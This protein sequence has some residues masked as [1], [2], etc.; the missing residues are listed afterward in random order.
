MKN[1]LNLISLLALF[2]VFGSVAEAAFFET[3]LGTGA[4]NPKTEVL[5]LQQFLFDRGFLKVAPTGNYLGLTTVAVKAFQNSQGIETTGFFGPLSRAA[6]NKILA[7]ADISEVS[8]FS[9]GPIKG[10]N[11]VASV[12]LSNTREI[13]WET[14][15]YPDNVGVNI[16]LLR[17]ISD[18]PTE[19]VLVRQIAK[20]TPNDGIEIWTPVVSDGDKSSLF[21]EVTCSTTYAFSG[22]CRF[23]GKTLK[24][25]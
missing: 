8:S 2:F 11:L 22:E 24:A 16:N 17:K 4:N 14:K 18:N 23:S 20:D 13:K 25:F 21:I 10:S 9:V 12:A 6:A 1:Y 5:K 3:P 15:N 7:N 19:Y